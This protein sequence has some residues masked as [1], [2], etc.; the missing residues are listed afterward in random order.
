[1]IEGERL[2]HL[3]RSALVPVEPPEALT[4][5]LERSLSGSPRRPPR[6]WPTWSRAAMR[7]PR[8][9]AR[10][11]AAAMVRQHGAAARSCWCARAS[12]SASAR[13]AA[14]ARSRRASATLAGDLEK[15]LRS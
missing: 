14:C 4:D 10:P 7:D 9:W 1:M 11:A 5:R 12:G 2:E 13:R 15:R 3:L 6:S 8:N